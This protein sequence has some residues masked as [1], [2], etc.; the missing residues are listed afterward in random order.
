MQ[1]EP[2]Q[3]WDIHHRQI[4]DPG[5]DDERALETLT[6]QADVVGHATAL[7]RA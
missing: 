3:A 4:H 7:A 5:F 2:F 1:D 6:E